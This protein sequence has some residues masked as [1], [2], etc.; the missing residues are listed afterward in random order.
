MLRVSAVANIRRLLSQCFYHSE[1][2]KMNAGVLPE[3]ARSSA[4][5]RML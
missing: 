5:A 4:R 2:A 3:V 1:T